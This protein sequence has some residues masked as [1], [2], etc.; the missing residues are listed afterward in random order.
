MSKMKNKYFDDINTGMEKARLQNLL[1]NIKT[2]DISPV[3]I[4]NKVIESDS[5]RLTNDEITEVVRNFYKF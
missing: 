4:I 2:E 3:Y 1:L 5:F